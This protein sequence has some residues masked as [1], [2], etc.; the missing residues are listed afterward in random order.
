L[1]DAV[2]LAEKW[3]ATRHFVTAFGDCMIRGASERPLARLLATHVA[4]ESDATALGERIPIENAS[5]YG[6]LNPKTAIPDAALD[7]F[8]MYGVV[9]KPSPALAPSRYAVAARWALSP[10]VFDWLRQTPV[11]AGG[12]LQLTDAVQLMIQAGGIAWGVPLI[13]GESRWD[14]G[15]W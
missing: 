3:V 8:P 13:D 2:S 12:E 5:K 4:N 7:P 15:G 14:I 10:G 9:E 11:S 6:I 1:G